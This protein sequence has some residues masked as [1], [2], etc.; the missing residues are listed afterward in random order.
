MYLEDILATDSTNF[1]PRVHFLFVLFLALRD[2]ATKIYLRLLPCVGLSLLVGCCY[3]FSKY[4]RSVKWRTVG[5]ALCLQF[6]MCVLILR[7]PI[8]LGAIHYIA[9]KAQAL[10]AHAGAGSCFVFSQDTAYSVWAFMVLP[11]TI[12]FSSLC[13][14]LLHL[15]ILQVIF[16]EAGG[17]LAY[18]LGT[19]KAEAVCAVANV[20][21]GQTEAPL[22][23]RPTYGLRAIFLAQ[24]TRSHLLIPKNA[25]TSRAQT[26]FSARLGLF[27]E[28][29]SRLGGFL[30]VLFL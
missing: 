25:F 26:H 29:A 18:L 20:M 28:K 4:R 1:Y 7:T 2:G 24:I 9:E 23:V 15:N 21:L 27:R 11:V 12:F 14:V 5:V 22:L 19:S 8:G 30:Y 16:G 17:L 10:L 13:M 3:V 6:W